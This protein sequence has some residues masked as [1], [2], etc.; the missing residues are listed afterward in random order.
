M[1]KIIRKVVVWLLVVFMTINGLG[2]IDAKAENSSLTE[3][4][5]QY[6]EIVPENLSCYYGYNKLASMENGVQM[7]ELYMKINEAAWDFYMSDESAVEDSSGVFVAGSVDVSSYTLSDIEIYTVIEYFKMDNPIYYF[8]DTP[9]GKQISYDSGKD[10]MQL[11]TSTYF[12]DE[13]GE[14]LV[15]YRSNQEH[16]RSVIE[17]KLHEYY[18]LTKDLDSNYEKQKA[19][20]SKLAFDVE[21]S[22]SD[23]MSPAVH[24]IMGALEDE[25]A[26]CEGFGYTFELIC[27]YCGID[28]IYIE[29]E[30]NGVP[31]GWNAV[32]YDDQWF[33]CDLTYDEVDKITN[34]NTYYNSSAMYMLDDRCQYTYFNVPK[35]YFNDNHSEYEYSL[36]DDR[37]IE[38]PDFT[39]STDFWFM[40]QEGFDLNFDSDIK[41]YIKNQIVK[42]ETRLDFYY[43]SALFDMQVAIEPYLTE[44][45]EEIKAETGKIY[46]LAAGHMW[47]STSMYGGSTSSSNTLYHCI[48][49]INEKVDN[50]EYIYTQYNIPMNG[51]RLKGVYTDDIRINLPKEID[52]KKVTEIS[53]YNNVSSPRQLLLPDNLENFSY[54]SCT[55]VVMPENV[56]EVLESTLK[57]TLYDNLNGLYIPQS[58]IYISGVGIKSYNGTY[59]VVDGYKIYGYADSYAETYANENGITF[60]DVT[61]KNKIDSIIIEN[62]TDKTVCE[63][64]SIPNITVTNISIEEDT[65][66]PIEEDK[67]KVTVSVKADDGY[68][69]TPNTLVDL[70]GYIADIKNI[71]VDEAEISCMILK[72][73]VIEPVLIE[74]ITINHESQSLMVDD[75]D[76]LTYQIQ[77]ENATNK[78][79]K[80]SSSDESVIII[81]Y[82]DESGCLVTAVGGGTAVVTGV[83]Q[84]GS[85]VKCSC[86]YEVES[87]EPDIQYIDIGQADVV[88]EKVYLCGNDYAADMVVTIDGTIISSDNYYYTVEYD[89]D[90]NR[91]VIEIT[92]IGDIYNGVK[93]VYFENEESGSSTEPEEP[94]P[95]EPNPDNP[96]PDEPTVDEPTTDEPEA[97]KYYPAIKVSYRTHIQSYGW[98]GDASDIKTWKSDGTMSGTSGKAK[99]LEGINIVVNSAEAG[100]DVDLG[101]QYTTHCQS[102]GWL[103]WSADGDM[104]GTEGEAKRLEAIKIQLTGADKDAYDV[105]YRVHAQSYGWLNWAKNGAPSGTAGYGK[106]LE[107]IQIVVVKKGESFNQKMEGI[108]SVRTESYIAKEGSSPI[109]NYAPTSN[110]NPVIPGDDTPNVAYRTHVQS[111]GWQGW[112][113]NG[114]MSGTSGLA[115][116]LEGININLTNKPCDGDIVYTTHVQTYGWKDGNPEDTSRA[117]WKKNGEM[118]GTSG[119][120]KRLEAI[121]IDLTGEMGEKYDIYY[122]VHAQSFGWL[123]WAKNGEESGTAGYAKRLEGIQIVLVPKGGAAPANDF[124]GVTSVRTE[125]YIQK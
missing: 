19:I 65:V 101:I 5:Q 77:P 106:R 83:A 50:G 82:Y 125:G 112:K 15:D 91:Y 79:I 26:V 51:I 90:E 87:D 124:G 27:N 99:R 114:Q 40:E 47:T 46:T 110:T 18:D 41:E 81:N 12:D 123:G 63:D 38:Y 54:E 89:E 10:K 24:S 3:Q 97:P 25:K 64:I 32:K 14:Y 22:K 17:D 62:L 70:N 115:K 4:T 96:T 29:G 39:E 111:F 121:C 55:Q 61:G 93:T 35:S 44:A 48:V 7:Q 103:P 104:N 57:S 33:L 107:G 36:E 59:S 119:E 95:E 108:A 113:Y 52:G 98:E 20:Y 122:R 73:D 71:D 16:F 67:Y 6:P 49:G 28:C 56:R 2:T 117:S 66:W 21:Y 76:I 8:L 102:Y 45:L 43:R 86:T 53:Y 109:V 60:V 11:I 34:K 1:K 31:H 84:D 30:S 88:V 68:T 80:W 105:Y 23:V 94:T 78:D 13:T 69:I 92:A 85:N 100:K 74:S 58:V 120:A 75:L 72:T 118:S 116:R 9:F 37:Y 42:G